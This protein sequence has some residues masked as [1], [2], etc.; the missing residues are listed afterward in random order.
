MP[1]DL[2]MDAPTPDLMVTDTTD[3][4][5]STPVSTQSAPEAARPAVFPVIPEERTPIYRQ[6]ADHY[7][8]A[9]EAGTLVSGA[10]MPSVRALMERHQ[11]SLSTALQTCRHL[12]AQGLLEARPRSGYF[13]RTPAR[14]S[15]VPVAEPRPWVPD[16]MQYVGINQ[17]VS[18]ILARGLQA[19]IKINFAIAHG[20]ASLYPVNELRQ[21]TIRALRD[22][23]LIYGM[24][25]PGG[26]DARFRGALARRALEARMNINPDEIIVTH[27]CIEAINLALRA[28]ASTGDV[29][30]VESPTYYALLQTLESMGI[31]A[32]EIPTSPQTGISLDALELASQT[33]DNIKAVI[34]VPHF[35]NPLGSVMPDANKM[36]LVKWAESRGIAIIEDDT[37]SALGDDGNMPAAIRSWDTTGNVI[38]C[39]SLHKTL[40][41]GMRLGWIAAGKW[42][43]RVD[44]LKYAQTRPNEAL[45][46]IAMGEFMDS[47]RFDRHL[48]RLRSQL[49]EHRAAM[50]EA[51]A[52]YFPAGTRLTQPAGGLSLWVEMPGGVSSERLFDAALEKGIRIA[53][54]SLFS[55]SARYDN[56]LRMN[57]GQPFT[58]DVDKA[59]RTLATEVTR[60]LDANG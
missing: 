24:P 51:I 46:Q 13:V 50:A 52:T 53:P 58:R 48:R 42:Q 36:Q 23:P 20:S 31:R 55:N 19:D 39:A 54:G 41:P 14:A 32:L 3:P 5:A 22:H 16:L 60:L 4:M 38:H 1:D 59:V 9:I 40:S 44:M 6:L 25:P 2:R 47:P 56:F 7:R 11:I 45:A 27:G 33:Y 17:R 37:Y 26:G 15:A 35:Q 34:V 57:G 28:V 8:L 12:E 21:A 43:R 10:R 30:A 49:R 29:V 18:S